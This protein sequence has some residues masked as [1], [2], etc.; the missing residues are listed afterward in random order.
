MLKQ[1]HKQM[2]VEDVLAPSCERISL[3]KSMALCFL[4]ADFHLTRDEVEKL[5]DEI[6][7]MQAD[8]K[9]VNAAHGVA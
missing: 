6:A 9:D 4:H 8:M 7:D 5:T 2:G 1:Q 3:T